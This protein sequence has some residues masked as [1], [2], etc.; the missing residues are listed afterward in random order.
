MI[1]PVNNMTTT[2]L[3]YNNRK[4]NDVNFKGLINKF[5]PLN[6]YMEKAFDRFT[7][8][9]KNRWMPVDESLKSHLKIFNFTK[10]KNTTE[11]W[12][13]NP[14][15]TEKYV[16][17][18]HGLGQNV[19]S[20]QEMYKKIIEKGYA[21]LAPEYGAF[22]N[23]TGKLSKKTITENAKAAIEY[24]N[25][26]GISNNNIGVV[27]FS[28]GSFPAIDT[29]YRNKNIKF[30][31]L[32]SPFNSMRNEAEVL[33][34]G[35][36]VRLPK[37]IRYSLK[38]CP[39]LLNHLDTIFKTKSKIKKINAPVYLIH[40]E[41]DKIVSKKSSEEL[42]KNAINLKEFILLEKGGHTIEE[43]KLNA[44]GMLKEFNK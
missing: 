1:Y 39:F 37:I 4:Q 28:M 5:S 31:V 43:Y 33:A 2:G 8:I 20:N 27:G 13:I 24:L 9:S 17:F 32:I 16:I 3:W 14:N 18:Y 34:K 30:L 42:A 26:K 44:F 35:T 25:K 10:G 11:V 23:S 41:N 38:K 12:D 29:A 22:G 40:S 15:N 19:S 21:V 7:Y 6:F 36:T